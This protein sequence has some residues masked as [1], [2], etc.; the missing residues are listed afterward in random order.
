M[1][2][3][4]IRPEAVRDETDARPRRSRWPLLASL[5][6]ALGVAATLAFDVHPDGYFDVLT[7]S[8]VIDDVSRGRAHASVAVGFVVVA[9]LTVLAGLWRARVEPRIPSSAAAKTVGHGFL[10]AAG[11][12]A[13]GYGFKG[14]FAVYLPGGLNEGDFDR[15]ALYTMYVLNDFGSFIGWIGVA[16]SAGA[17]AWLA[18]RDRVVS[19]WIGAVSILLLLP[20]VG[21]TVATGLPGFA[22]LTMP[23]WLVVVGLGLGLGRS[24]I[25]R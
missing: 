15:E 10:A 11:A 6:G 24:T 23:L 3:T 2:A 13:L 8:G 22:G 21:M 18:L 7:T 12:L 16:V 1:S 17:M 4:T 5:T 25:V 19:R 20:V 9:L 14:M